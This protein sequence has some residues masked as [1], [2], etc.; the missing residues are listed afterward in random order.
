MW[1]ERRHIYIL[2]C[3]VFCYSALLAHVLWLCVSMM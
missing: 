2:L 3:F 1:I